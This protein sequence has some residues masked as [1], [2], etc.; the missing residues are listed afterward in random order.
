[1]DVKTMDIIIALTILFALSFQVVQW[2]IVIHNLYDKKYKTRKEFLLRM[3]PGYFLIIIT[4][5]CWRLF[6]SFM[7]LQ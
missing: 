4:K 2:A 7:L 6:E 5:F 3:I 1:M